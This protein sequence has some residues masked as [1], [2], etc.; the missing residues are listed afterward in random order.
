MAIRVLRG[1]AS[2][3]AGASVGFVLCGMM[4][5]EGGLWSRVTL[6]WTGR[7]TPWYLYSNVMLGW[8]K[9]RVSTCEPRSISLDEV[10]PARGR[11]HFVKIRFFSATKAR[12]LE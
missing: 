6:C 3:I 2:D 10:E 5:N 11:K 4:R 1:V 12:P 7:M 8:F 9:L